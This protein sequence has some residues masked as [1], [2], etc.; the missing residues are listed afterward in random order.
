MQTGY[1]HNTLF[2]WRTNHI[3]SQKQQQKR[4][5]LIIALFKESNLL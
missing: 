5:Q 2:G 3:Y 4:R 1:C